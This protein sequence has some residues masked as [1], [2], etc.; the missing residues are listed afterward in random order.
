MHQ[1]NVTQLPSIHALHICLALTMFSILVRDSGIFA[2]LHVLFSFISIVHAGFV[3]GK[4]TSLILVYSLCGLFLKPLSCPG[5]IH[6]SKN[7]QKM[8]T[9]LGWLS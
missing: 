4:K 9:G 7:L 1:T 2:K 3:L 8:L 6:H 5:L